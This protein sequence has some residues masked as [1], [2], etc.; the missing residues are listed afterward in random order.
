M[1]SSYRITATDMALLPRILKFTTPDR[2]PLRFHL[3]DRVIHGIPDEFRPTVTHRILDCNMVQYLIEG[4][5]NDG[6]F[7]RAEYLEY[8]DFPVTEWVVTL[9]NRGG[10]DTPILSDL[11]LGGEIA[12]ENGEI[13]VPGCHAGFYRI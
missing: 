12:C 2:I 3:G 7:I 11:R 8:R 1:N 13:K 4:Q 10:T 6:L 9:T 5:N